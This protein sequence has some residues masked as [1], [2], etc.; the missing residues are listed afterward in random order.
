[1]K[2]NA[3]NPT[4]AIGYQKNKAAWQFSGNTTTFK[5]RVDLALNSKEYE[6]ING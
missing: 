3:A 6:N 4:L 2:P 1:M 5:S